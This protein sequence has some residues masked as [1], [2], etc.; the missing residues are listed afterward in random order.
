MHSEIKILRAISQHTNFINKI[1]KFIRSG[2][3]EN[4]NC[5]AHT[6]CQFGSWYYGEGSSCMEKESNVEAKRVWQEVGILHEQF[7]REFCGA[8]NGSNNTDEG[9]KISNVLIQKLM[10]LGQLLR[11][12]G[13]GLVKAA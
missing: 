1:E 6:E 3:T 2:S 12:K 5:P 4:F 10:L 7:H 9:I 13:R 11:P 8:A